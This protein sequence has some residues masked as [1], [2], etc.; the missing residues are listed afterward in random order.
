MTNADGTENRITK[1]ITPRRATLAVSGPVL[2]RAQAFDEANNRLQEVSYRWSV[3][4]GVSVTMT[5]EA[6][7]SL[8]TNR[9]HITTEIDSYN[10]VDP[11]MK[12]LVGRWLFATYRE[13]IDEGVGV[14][15]R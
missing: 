9:G 13:C 6:C 8:K 3:L 1:A 11:L 5:T 15:M 12:R 4:D 14:D 10:D 2:F 7:A